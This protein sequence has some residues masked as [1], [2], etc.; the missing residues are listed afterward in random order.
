VLLLLVDGGK[1]GIETVHQTRGFA[2]SNFKPGLVDQCSD[3]TL[4]VPGCSASFCR[5][6]VRCNLF[7]ILLIV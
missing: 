3:S 7:V 4:K 2:K 5:W 1:V 6:T